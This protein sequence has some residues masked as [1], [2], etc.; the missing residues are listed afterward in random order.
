VQFLQS[1]VVSC[2]SCSRQVALIDKPSI[3]NTRQ[4]H[5]GH[6]KC[7]RPFPLQPS[8]GPS[9]SIEQSSCIVTSG[10][11]VRSNRAREPSTA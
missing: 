6:S 5:S 3:F 4:G 2:L 1:A 7:S 9:S 8:M 10:S 11:A